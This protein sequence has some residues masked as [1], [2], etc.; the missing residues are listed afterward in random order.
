MDLT[1]LPYPAR[2]SWRHDTRPN[3]NPT[4]NRSRRVQ[5]WLTCGLRLVVAALGKVV[6][7]EDMERSTF[8][9]GG[10]AV[11]AKWYRTFN[12]FLAAQKK[13]VSPV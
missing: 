13:N 2:P 5:K 9:G 12:I 1:H 11:D 3:P 10:E 8:W 7:W 6:K 4:C